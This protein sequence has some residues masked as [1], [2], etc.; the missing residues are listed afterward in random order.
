MPDRYRVGYPISRM[1]HPGLRNHLCTGTP[2]N[3]YQ[4]MAGAVGDVIVGSTFLREGII[5]VKTVC[6]YPSMAHVCIFPQYHFKI[7]AQRFYNCFSVHLFKD[8]VN[9][10]TAGLR[11]FEV[12]KSDPGL[13]GKYQVDAAVLCS[14]NKQQST[15]LLSDHT[16]ICF[17]QD[18][19]E[20]GL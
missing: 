15:E 7:F 13:T 4:L 14:L 20:N 2:F 1:I 6:I 16:Y 3:S 11:K 18:R 17:I 12:E 10:K 9:F 5:T 19:R 8:I